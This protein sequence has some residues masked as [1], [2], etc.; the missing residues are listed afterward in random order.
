LSGCR[1][2]SPKNS[3]NWLAIGVSA[4]RRPERK[5]SSTAGSEAKGEVFRIAR[6]RPARRAR[7]AANR[8]FIVKGREEE[9]MGERNGMRSDEQ[10]DLL[11]SARKGDMAPM[12]RYT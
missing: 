11:A 12:A 8:L 10:Q 6:A 4:T 7:K 1:D 2:V 5:P 3:C 9:R